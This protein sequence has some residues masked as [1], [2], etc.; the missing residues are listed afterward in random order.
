MNENV[1]KPMN[2][3]KTGIEDSPLSGCV[4]CMRADSL[5]ILRHV[6]HCI[7]RPL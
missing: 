4:P 1:K 7:K 6:M 2:G 3:K 5:P